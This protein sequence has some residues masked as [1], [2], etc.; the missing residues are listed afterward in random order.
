[1]NSII[2]LTTDFGRK[3]AYVGAMKGVILGINPSA[4]IVDLSHEIEPLNIRQGSLVLASAYPFFPKGTVHV[5][6]VDPGVGSG[7]KLLCVKIG[8]AYFM[9][10]DN[11]L[12]TPVFEAEK[13]CSIREI[14]NRE[15]FRKN[16]SATFHGRDILA[17]AAGWLSKKDIF[18]RLGPVVSCCKRL[19]WPAV[20]RLKDGIRGEILAVDH[21]GNLITNIK[22]SD[23]PGAIDRFRVKAGKRLISVW[24]KCYADGKPGR[25]MALISSMDYLEI[26]VPNG[27]A[28]ALTGLK[29]GQE[30][31]V[32]K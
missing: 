27:S 11:G 5:A 17:S 32:T 13:S 2:T 3:D 18:S 21:F 8:S 25:P 19:A 30:V 7:R 28:A 14:S 23:L 12:L 22:A 20:K 1:M 26:A 16:I 31:T 29:P 9:A 15:F 4:R 24:G 6:V 10:P